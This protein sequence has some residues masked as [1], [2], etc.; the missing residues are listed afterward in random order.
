M[1]MTMTENIDRAAVEA[2]LAEH[3]FVPSY[4][5]S[6]SGRCAKCHRPEL[7][8]M[9]GHEVWER[10][11][12]ALLADRLPQ[13][14]LDPERARALVETWRQESMGR[15]GGDHGLERCGREVLA[16]LDD[17]SAT[18]PSDDAALDQ[19]L[20]ERD[21]AQEWADRLAYAIAPVEVIGEHTSLNNPWQNAW[22]MAA[23]TLHHDGNHARLPEGVWLDPGFCADCDRERATLPQ[24][25]AEQEAGE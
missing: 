5:G 18:L 20:A 8:D 15:V 23:P 3:R 7:R 2:L 4:A 13:R 12:A 21:E 25:G 16:L 22:D 10:H 14:G 1:T 17:D 9:I 19:A 6:P 11:I 24:R